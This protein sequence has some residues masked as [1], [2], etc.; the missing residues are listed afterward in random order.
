MPLCRTCKP[1]CTTGL[2]SLSTAASCAP[3]MVQRTPTTL[4]ER[5]PS[6]SPTGT[7]PAS[8]A[9]P[10]L[11]LPAANQVEGSIPPCLVEAP[12]VQEI[13]LANNRLS[14][15][16]PQ[17]P[18]SSRLLI[19]SAHSNV[20]GGREGLPRRGGAF[21]ATSKMTLTQSSKQQACSSRHCLYCLPACLPPHSPMPHYPPTHC[22]SVSPG[23]C[24]RWHSCNSCRRW[25][26]MTTSSLGSCPSCPTA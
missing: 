7:P 9:R 23:A 20:G 4:P 17:P 26:C 12:T 15:T 1:L 21:N 5:S 3:Y 24:Q 10:T 6:D 25:C 2:P 22:C 19:I 8:P 16:L 14:G 11:S 18:A 13:Y